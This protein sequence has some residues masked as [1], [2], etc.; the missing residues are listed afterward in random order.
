MRSLTAF[1]LA[2]ILVLAIA[3]APQAQEQPTPEKKRECGTTVT[4]RQ[5]EV[6]LARK[7]RQAA[8]VA[9]EVDPPTQAPYYLPLTIHIVRRS[10][11]T[12]GITLDQLEIA[13]QDLNRMWQPVGI[14]FFIY[15]AIDYINNDT[16]F[17]VPNMNANQDALRQ[18]NAVA[19]TINVYF[20]NL[21]G[22]NGKSSFTA[23]AVQ[24]VLVD[25]DSAG[26]ATNPST[27]A[28][29]IGHYFDLYHTHETWP[30]NMGN[31][32]AVECP[33][34]NNCS[35]AGDQL[36]DTPADPGLS[37]LVNEACTYIG[38]ATTPRSC[39]NTPYNPLTRNLMSYSRAT[40]RSEFTPNQLSKVLQVLRDTANRKNLIIK[41]ARYVDPLAS[42]SNADCSYNFPCRTVPKAI[43]VAL[44][45]DF[46]FIKPGTH[47][48]S[49]LGGKRVTLSK[50]GTIGVVQITQ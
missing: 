28:H 2:F 34:G 20:T 10:D 18:V 36:C 9:P 1:I 22:L 39:D 5:L 14:Q 12:G 32:T 23:D 15:G 31:P 3:P 11:R 19:N 16:H 21:M 6:E 44:H 42:L 8:L 37:G 7:A 41:G 33:S 13:M 29:E 35:T 50:W 4:P 49:V 47:Q 27:F 26:V 17:N 38:S 25:I 45:G 40:C 46:I 48:A 43:Q 30:D 24:G